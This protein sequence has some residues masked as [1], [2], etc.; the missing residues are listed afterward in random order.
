MCLSRRYA[1]HYK[2]HNTQM[3]ASLRFRSF[4]CVLWFETPNTVNFA[5][6][7]QIVT[8]NSVGKSYRNQSISAMFASLGTRSNMHQMKATI[9]LITFSDSLSEQT[10]RSNK[11]R[12]VHLC[13][14]VRI[15]GNPG[16]C[17]THS[18]TYFY[19]FLFDV[20]PTF[21]F[22]D[23]VCMA[24]QDSSRVSGTGLLTERKQFQSI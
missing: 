22:Q 17:F 24:G 15:R 1:Q 11:H 3:L 13:A 16:N 14:S 6:N 8:W 7:V 9:S 19:S 21:L 20:Y 5:D 23:C 10:R 2:R 12:H 4:S 18:P